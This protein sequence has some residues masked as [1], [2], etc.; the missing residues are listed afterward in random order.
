MK[1]TV[2]VMPKAEKDLR[3][4]YRYIYVELVS[5]QAA[6]NVLNALESSIMGLDSLPFRFR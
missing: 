3:D 1:Y 2:I 6:L 5:P 4:I